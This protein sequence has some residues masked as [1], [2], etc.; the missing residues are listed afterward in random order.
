MRPALPRAIA[1]WMS[2]PFVF[3]ALL[4]FEGFSSAQV[5]LVSSRDHVTGRTLSRKRTVNL[6][7][8]R[9]GISPV[10]PPNTS[11]SGWRIPLS[12]MA[13]ESSTRGR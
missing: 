5:R 9:G 10:R 12:W 13:G 4:A 7:P 3:L 6:V 1:R 8:V 11:D 2:V